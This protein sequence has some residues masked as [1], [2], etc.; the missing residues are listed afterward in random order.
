MEKPEGR[1]N[2]E[3]PV[4]DGRILLKWILDEWVVCTNWIDLTQERDRCRAVVN[5]VM[6]LRVS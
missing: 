5:A 3:A 4:I 2:S 1:K 6:N